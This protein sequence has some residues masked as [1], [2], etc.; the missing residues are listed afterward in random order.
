[1]SQVFFRKPAVVCFVVGFRNR[2]LVKP[3][4]L[5]PKRFYHVTG[6]ATETLRGDYVG[7]FRKFW[8]RVHSLRSYVAEISFAHQTD[9]LIITN[10]VV[11][12]MPRFYRWRL[13]QNDFGEIL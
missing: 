13:F 2:E 10:P 11:V 4:T 3:T 12:L 5:L 8:L 9:H 1:M 7:E 6:N